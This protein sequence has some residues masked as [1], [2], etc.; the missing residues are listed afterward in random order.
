[1]PKAKVASSAEPAAKARRRAAKEQPEESAEMQALAR[2]RNVAHPGDELGAAELARRV[3]E[4]LRRFRQER[5]LS[6]D[7]LAQRSGVSRAALSQ[8]EGRRTNPTL[9]VLWKIAVGLDVPFH[10]LLGGNQDA[11]ILVLRA[12]DAPPM[13]SADGRTESRLLS[14]GGSSTNAEVY[15][16]KL[17]PK[18]V[19]KSEAHAR[20]TTETLIVLVGNMRLTVGGA[21]QEVAAGDSVFFRADMDHSYENVGGRE[22][23]CINVIHYARP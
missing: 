12:G 14:P 16:L 3:A 1:M 20:G 13:R 5:Q 2:S 4:S 18:A 9:S 19:H 7:D 22:A 21:A 6:L 17:L 15:E 8:I 10:D 23:R 11:P